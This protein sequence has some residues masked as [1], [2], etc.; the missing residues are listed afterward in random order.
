ME[1]E[2]PI[3]CDLEG[4]PTV[5]YKDKDGYY[6][7]I[8]FKDGKWGKELKEYRD[9][10]DHIFK[11]EFGPREGTGN[12]SVRARGIK[13]VSGK[14][15]FDLIPPEAMIEL[16]K[17]YTEGAEHYGDRNFEKG[18]P[19]DECLGAMER[20]IMRFKLGK[21]IGEKGFHEMAHVAFWCL[22]LIS[23]YY[24]DVQVED[25]R[26]ERKVDLEKFKD[27]LES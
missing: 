7:I 21:D 1:N 17:V 8:S 26:K 27:F 11:A 6:C 24:R 20:H 16:A 14:L 22:A 19:T 2:Y 12:I 15:R 18:I 23:Q 10:V 3:F 25:C 5:K 9:S 4:F 13:E